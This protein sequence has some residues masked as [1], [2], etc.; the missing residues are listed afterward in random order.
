LFSPDGGHNTQPRYEFHTK[1]DAK[2][3]L[4][5]L[6]YDLKSGQDRAIRFFANGIF[7]WDG[8][9]FFLVKDQFLTSGNS[10]FNKGLLNTYQSK[11]NA[12][13]WPSFRR[14]FIILQN[15]FNERKSSVPALAEAIDTIT[16]LISFLIDIF[17]DIYLVYAGNGSDTNYIS[18]YR[19][20][21][22]STIEATG[23]QF[24][25][26]GTGVNYNSLPYAQRG[27]GVSPDPISTLLKFDGGQIFATFSSESGDT[28]L[29]EDLKVDF[30]RSTIEGQAFS[31][32]VQNIALPLIIGVGG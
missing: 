20:G 13:L 31:R 4:N 23:Q 26:S 25:Y 21:M 30:K 22:P 9:P 1:R 2:T 17:D 18:S 3:I 6:A 32:G 12:N 5:Q 29:G 10:V 15:I 27:S 16:A 28:Y 19:E 7:D 24:S 11:F 14:C 8:T